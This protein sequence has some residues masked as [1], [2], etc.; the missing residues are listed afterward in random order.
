MTLL[1]F[2][3]F[4][5]IVIQNFYIRYLKKEICLRDGTYQ[6]KESKLK[7]LLLKWFQRRKDES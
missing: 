6:P 4:I 3:L 5:I 2:V 1:F 7:R